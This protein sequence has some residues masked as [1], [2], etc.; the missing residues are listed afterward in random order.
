MDNAESMCSGSPCTTGADINTCCKDDGD[1]DADKAPACS[2]TDGSKASPFSTGSNKNYEECTCAGAAKE[3]SAL[4][5]C[6]VVKKTCTC[7]PGKDHWCYNDEERTYAVKFGCFL[8]GE[9][10]GK[11]KYEGFK[12]DGDNVGKKSYSDDKC[13][14]EL[15]VENG[16]RIQTFTPTKVTTVRMSDGQ[17]KTKDDTETFGIST[18]KGGVAGA[19]AA[20]QGDLAKGGVA[21]A[22]ASDGAAAPSPAPAGKGGAAAPSPTSHVFLSKGAAV[23]DL[24]LIVGLISCLLFALL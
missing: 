24:S 7:T 14:T 22:G 2:V 19:G 16:G 4:N 21:G 20:A 18:C 11:K 10:D 13:T 6:D 15:T 5:V 12:C 17:K 8:E 3:C 9:K 23:A 1:D